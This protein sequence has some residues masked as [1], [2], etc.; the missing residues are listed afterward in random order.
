MAAQTVEKTMVLIVPKP[1]W[2]CKH[3][4]CC[5]HLTS[6]LGKNWCVT[7]AAAEGWRLCAGVESAFLQFA[8]QTRR[9]HVQL[10]R[11]A[12]KMS[13]RYKRIDGSGEN[14]AERVAIVSRCGSCF[15]Q[16]PASQAMSVLSCTVSLLQSPISNIRGR[17]QRRSSFSQIKMSTLVHD[18]SP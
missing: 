16:W 8:P 7:L 10:P 5:Y 12:A 13:G 17:C 9:V 15:L 1:D 11:D 14:H 4:M 2:C 3:S 6:R 18:F